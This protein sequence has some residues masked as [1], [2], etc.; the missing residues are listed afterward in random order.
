M[1]LFLASSAFIVQSEEQPPA[2]LPFHRDSLPFWLREPDTSP[3]IAV[4]NATEISS[5]YLMRCLAFTSH[6]I[7]IG[8]D[9]P[10]SLSRW[11]KREMPYR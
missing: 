9:I 3:S 7:L 6:Y 8:Y 2:M 5:I 4:S 1:L 10:S 11:Q